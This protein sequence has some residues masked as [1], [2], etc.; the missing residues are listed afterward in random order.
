MV[1]TC[2]NLGRFHSS[3]DREGGC[4][5]TLARTPPEIESRGR[6]YGPPVRICRRG[7][8]QEYMHILKITAETER[9][10]ANNDQRGFYKGQY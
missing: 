1:R 10:L 3:M 5:T 8:P 7:L 9:I 6:R 4:A 2:L